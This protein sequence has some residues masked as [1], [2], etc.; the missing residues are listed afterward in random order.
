MTTTLVL[1]S[2]LT[3]SVLWPKKGRHI[4][5]Q[6]DDETIIVYQAYRAEIAH[7]AISHG[8]FG[9]GFS[10]ERMSWIKPT[11]LWMMYRSGWGTRPGQEMTLSIRIRR[12]FFDSLLAQAVES[13]YTA[14][15]HASHA[16]WEKAIKRSSVRIQWDPD[17]HPRGVA[18]DR[19]AIQ[20]GLKGKTLQQYARQQIL[21]IIDL[22]GFVTEQREN[23]TAARISALLTPSERVYIPAD[24]KIQRHIQL[25]VDQ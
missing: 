10:Y 15:Q 11:F 9:E 12:S 21:E 16:D 23:I 19:R 22:T 20:L 7:F 8:Y 1:A 2:Y 25:D 14:D 6:Y 5:A 24:P 3:Q 13:S 17:H 4:L 18:L